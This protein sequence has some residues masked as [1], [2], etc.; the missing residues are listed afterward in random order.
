NALV[1]G[2]VNPLHTPTLDVPMPRA[3]SSG[4]PAVDAGRDT[5]MARLRADYLFA[6]KAAMSRPEHDGD[7]GPFALH[8]RREEE[9]L[10]WCPLSSLMAQKESLARARL[11]QRTFCSTALT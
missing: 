9:L 1:A 5:G 6:A 7:P 8:A 10:D 11:S 2:Q 4:I 3:L